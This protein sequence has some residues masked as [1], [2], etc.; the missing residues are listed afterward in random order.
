[1]GTPELEA[2]LKMIIKEGGE[3]VKTLPKYRDI[4]PDCERG[5]EVYEAAKLY[6]TTAKLALKEGDI[7]AAREALTL[8]NLVISTYFNELLFLSQGLYPTAAKLALKEGDINTLRKALVLQDSYINALFMLHDMESRAYEVG[9]YL[10]QQWK[11]PNI[12]DKKKKKS[13]PKDARNLTDKNRRSGQFL[14]ENAT[15]DEIIQN[16]IAKQNRSS[17]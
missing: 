13:V 12:Q 4:H 3:I 16:N 10:T 1:M 17:D 2:K 9:K 5:I 15:L 7:Y 6:N 14:D 8:Q 11:L